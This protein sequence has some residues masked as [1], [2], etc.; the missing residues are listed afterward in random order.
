MNQKRRHPEHATDLP[1][2]GVNE[3]R[4]VKILITMR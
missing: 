3:N 4:K 1:E 2:I